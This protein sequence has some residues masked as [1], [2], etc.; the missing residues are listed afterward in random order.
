MKKKKRMSCNWFEKWF[1]VIWKSNFEKKL[2]GRILV[3]LFWNEF[4]DNTLFYFQKDFLMR[5]L[6]KKKIITLKNITHFLQLFLS[7]KNKKYFKRKFCKTKKETKRRTHILPKEEIISIHED[8]AVGIPSWF[9]PKKKVLPLG[10]PWKNIF[11]HHDYFGKKNNRLN[12][13]LVRSGH[14]QEPVNQRTSQTWS[15]TRF[16]QVWPAVFPSNQWPI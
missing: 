14:D 3:Q 8:E 12:Q 9:S 13:T 10:Y 5:S 15:R 7:S 1:L 16:D 6:K 4:F 11:Q 2:G